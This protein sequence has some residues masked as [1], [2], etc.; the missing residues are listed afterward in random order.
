MQRR[1]P[2]RN[3]V[4]LALALE[5]QRGMDVRIGILDLGQR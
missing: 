1:Q 5:A 4:F 3:L 2:R